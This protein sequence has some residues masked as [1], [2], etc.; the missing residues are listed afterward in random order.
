MSYITFD[1]AQG[2]VEIG[3][4]ERARMGVLIDD[5]AWVMES[6]GR[7]RSSPQDDWQVKLQYTGPFSEDNFGERLGWLCLIGD[8]VTKLLAHIHGQ[9]EIH[10]WVHPEDGEWFA[11]LIE[12]AVARG[13][14]GNDGRSHYGSWTDV[15]DLARN[16]TTP[17]VSSYSVSESWPDPWTIAHERPDLFN[18][19]GPAVEGDDVLYDEWA[20]L[21]D[22]ERGRIADAAIESIGPRWH[23]SEWG[24]HWSSLVAGR[25]PYAQVASLSGE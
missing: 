24:T 11:S 9:C 12:E 15:A 17:L 5:I 22:D 19:T 16:S 6:R 2:C 13:L 23:P 18:P 4:R 7:A 20:A 25:D 21:T 10:G 3:G 8:D 14:L 1:S